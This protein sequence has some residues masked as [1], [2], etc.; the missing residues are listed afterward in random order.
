[1]LEQGGLLL[2]RCGWLWCSMLQRL[3]GRRQA[4]MPLRAADVYPVMMSLCCTHIMPCAV[5]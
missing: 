3:Y 2:C 4:S 5:Q 1:M